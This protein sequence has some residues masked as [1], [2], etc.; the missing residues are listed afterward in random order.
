MNTSVEIMIVLSIGVV[1]AVYAFYLDVRRT[2]A[3]SRLLAWLRSE[4]E[5]DWEGLS[6]ADRFLSFRAVEILRRGALAGD[7]EF[8]SR[9]APTRHGRRFVVAM[10]VTTAAIALVILGTSF[11]GWS[12]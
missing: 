8:Q 2:S 4:R 10:T 5:D 6:R 1:A 3:F 7:P 12:W 11:W 9:Y